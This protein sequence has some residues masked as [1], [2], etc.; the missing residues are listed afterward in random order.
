MLLQTASTDSSDELVT[1]IAPLAGAVTGAAEPRCAVRAEQTKAFQADPIIWSKVVKQFVTD[2]ACINILPWLNLPAPADVMTVAVPAACYEEIAAAA[3]LA[4]RKEAALAVLLKLMFTQAQHTL[5]ARAKSLQ[6]KGCSEDEVA[7][8]MHS[9]RHFSVADTVLCSMLLVHKATAVLTH[10]LGHASMNTLCSASMSVC[11][12]LAEETLLTSE[13]L[14]GCDLQCRPRVNADLVTAVIQQTMLQ[15]R[16]SISSCAFTVDHCV[17][18]LTLLAH[19]ENH[20]VIKQFL[21]QGMHQ[22]LRRVT[23]LP[24]AVATC[25]VGEYF[26]QSY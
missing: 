6:P 1:S 12:M 22:A 17:T 18:L 13:D 15:L 20:A 26:L 25:I 14:S 3:Q 11:E 2:Q 24:K 4:G 10:S 7:H 21:T 19:L 9:L 5:A 8:Q 23:D 16:S